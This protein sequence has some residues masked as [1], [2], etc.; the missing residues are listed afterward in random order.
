VYV[1]RD[2]ALAVFARDAGTGALTA[3]QTV[4]DGMGGT[5]GLA[6]VSD[7]VVS[8]DGA[9]VYVVGRLDDAVAVFA[10]NGSTGALSPRRWS[11]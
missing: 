10:R 9:Q 7:V 2:G 3:V 11:T 5:D 4:Q 1:A 6:G 8:P